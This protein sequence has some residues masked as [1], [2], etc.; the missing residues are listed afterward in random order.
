MA[1]LAPTE[2]QVQCSIVEYLRA[3]RL[4]H[5]HPPNEEVRG[6]SPAERA[7]R[8]AQ[9]RS[10]GVRA[11]VA[12]IVVVGCGGLCL[13]MECKRPGGRLS[14]AQTMFRADLGAV[15]APYVVVG[16]VE[17]AADALRAWLGAIVHSETPMPP[18][19]QAWAR[20]TLQRIRR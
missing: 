2:Y 18:A 6:R 15:G 10:A 13:H 7:R 16:G 11:G 20:E 4:V 14:A 12:D 5:Y 19:W 3:L 1:A 8:G 9:A 17:S